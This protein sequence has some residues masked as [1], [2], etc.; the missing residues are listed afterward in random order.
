MNLF[1][2]LKLIL[3]YRNPAHTSHSDSKE[4]VAARLATDDQ[5]AAGKAQTIHI[6][7]DANG[8]FDGYKLYSEREEKKEDQ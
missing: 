4:H 8:K 5:A 7:F 2:I 3:A 1:M 6:Y